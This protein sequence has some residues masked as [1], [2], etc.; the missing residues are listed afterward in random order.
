MRM[1]FAEVLELPVVKAGDPFVHHGGAKLAAAVRWVHVSELLEPAGTLNGG[2]LVL[3]TGALFQ[4]SGVD[5]K[6]YLSALIDAGAVGLIVERGQDVVALPE[7]LVRTARER[8]FPLVEFRRTVR[9]VSITEVVHSRIIN[10]QYERL[11]FSQRVHEIFASLGVEGASIEDVLEQTRL[12]CGYPVV[13]EDLAHRVLSFSSDVSVS[14]LLQQWE[15]RSRLAAWSAVTAAAGPEGWMTTPVGPREQRWGRLVVPVRTGADADRV[16]MA[17]E[18]AAE[19][20]TISRRVQRDAATVTF[21]AQSGLLQDLLRGRTTDERSLR[22]RARA[23]GLSVDASFVPV[24]L[25]ASSVRDGEHLSEYD[26]LEH[27]A[28]VASRSQ[29]SCIVGRLGDMQIGIV[30]SS[31]PGQE[32]TR[33]VDAFA[34]TFRADLEKSEVGFEVIISTAPTVATLTALASSMAEA[35]HVAAVASILPNR[36][37]SIVYRSLQLGVRGFLWWLRDDS[38]LHA[39]SEAQLQ[40]LLESKVKSEGGSLEMLRAYISAGGNMS[41]VAKA[42]H[43]SRSAAYARLERFKKILG[44]D[45]ADPETRLSLHLALIAYDQ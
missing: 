5:Y 17:L 32:A 42:L 38:R 14:D 10:A 12:V 45:P 21:G 11:E 22:A 35:G 7:T 20:L 4:T 44:V 26:I 43:V 19:T 39:F 37:T 9:F 29:S 33:A 23:L 34:R 24:V 27:V 18:R 6:A 41:E 13:L 16:A 15:A 3:T 28:R 40:P 36:D 8:D 25:Q 1:T 2:E 30:M 31:R